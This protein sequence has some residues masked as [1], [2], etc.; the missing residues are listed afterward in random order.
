MNRNF[1]IEYVTKKLDMEMNT[2]NLVHNQIIL[3]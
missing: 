3:I 2:E 1:A